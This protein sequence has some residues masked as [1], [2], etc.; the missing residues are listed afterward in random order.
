MTI[1]DEFFRNSSYNRHYINR[2]SHY[3][4]WYLDLLREMNDMMS[5]AL[6]EAVPVEKP[7]T[8]LVSTKMVKRNG[9][10][11]RITIEEMVDEESTDDVSVDVSEDNEQFDSDFTEDNA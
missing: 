6:D 11:Y 3:T 8:K 7:K 9:K 1:W 10:T 4:N 5:E 2:N